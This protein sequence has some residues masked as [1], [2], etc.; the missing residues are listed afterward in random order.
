MAL[1][2]IILGFVAVGFLLLI[3]VVSLGTSGSN[4]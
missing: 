3:F 1:A 2:G 4:G